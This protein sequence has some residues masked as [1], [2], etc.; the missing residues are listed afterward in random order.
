MQ[1]SWLMVG[2]SVHLFV[3]S[4][5]ILYTHLYVAKGVCAGWW[6]ASILDGFD[7]PD[8]YCS[9]FSGRR[10]VVHKQWA[11][12]RT[13]STRLLGHVLPMHQPLMRVCPVV[14]SN[15][16]PLHGVLSNPHGW[17]MLCCT[18]YL[19]KQLQKR[20]INAQYDSIRKVC[21]RR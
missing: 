20:R 17:L 21:W 7:Y 3:T 2:W 14:D 18:A 9:S 6:Y 1:A 16:Q 5:Y 19:A 4:P 8:V 15:R 11:P 10:I 13:G 12:I